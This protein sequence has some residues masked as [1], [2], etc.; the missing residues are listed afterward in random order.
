MRR[1]AIPP[2]TARAARAI[3]AITAIRS[4]TRTVTAAGIKARPGDFSGP[5]L[6]GKKRVFRK[7]LRR[8][9]R[10]RYT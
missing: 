3:T 10:F 4:A 5:P 6:R 2:P 1:T 9:I 7:I 8:Q